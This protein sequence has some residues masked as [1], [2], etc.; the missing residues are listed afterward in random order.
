MKRHKR[1]RQSF[2]WKTRAFFGVLAL[3][4]L[5]LGVGSLLRK[6]LVYRNFWDGPV[7]APYAILLGVLVMA[8]AIFQG[9]R[10]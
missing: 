4:L 2:N 3:I 5:S 7:F 6:Q 9:R 8:V 10:R 1:E